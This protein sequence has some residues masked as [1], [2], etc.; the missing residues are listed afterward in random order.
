M[1]E[2]NAMIAVTVGVVKWWFKLKLVSLQRPTHTYLLQ[3]NCVQN[4]SLL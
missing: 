1:I 2:D 4:L 3:R